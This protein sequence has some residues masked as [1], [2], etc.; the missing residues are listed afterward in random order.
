MNRPV[1]AALSVVIMSASLLVARASAR[2]SS[3]IAQDKNPELTFIGCLGAGSDEN[4]FSLTNA[5]EKGKTT[6]KTSY[7]L[8]AATKKV[9]LKAHVGH[10]V[11]VKGTLGPEVKSESL[12]PVLRMITATAVKWRAENCG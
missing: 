2:P 11:E 1:V 8:V 4:R 12:T 3:T 6:F 7:H 5:K 10:E 9:D